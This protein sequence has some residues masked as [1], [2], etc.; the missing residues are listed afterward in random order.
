[1]EASLGAGRYEDV[2]SYAIEIL[3]DSNDNI[4]LNVRFIVL[5]SKIFQGSEIDKKKLISDFLDHYETLPKGLENTWIYKGLIHMIE[6]SDLGRN[7]RESLKSLIDLIKNK[8][9]IDEF[10]KNFMI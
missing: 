5:C 3:A 8:T 4:N 2:N 6:N 10:K 7:D 9:S 1:M